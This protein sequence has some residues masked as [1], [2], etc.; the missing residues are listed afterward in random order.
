MMKALRYAFLLTVFC[1]SS[2]AADSLADAIKDGKVNGELRFWYFNQKTG[3]EKADILDL[4]V[5]LNYTTDS[6]YGFKGAFGFQSSNSPFADKDAKNMF[7]AANGLYGPGAVLSEAYI[8]YMYSK[9]ELKVGRQFINIPLVKSGMGKAVIQSFEGVTLTSGEIEGNTFYA[10]YISKFQKQTNGKGGAPNF[11]KL[12]GDYGYAIGAANNYFEKLKL[13][14]AYGGV[15]D[16]FS[17]IF[18]QADFQNSISNFNYQIAAQYSHTDYK[19]SALDD[20]NY[21]GVKFGVGFGDFNMYLAG[22]QI[23]DGNAQFGIAGGGNKCTL[24]TS[25]YEQCAE[26]EKSKQYAIDANYDFKSL[27]LLTGVR[28][29]HMDYEDTDDETDW[30]DVYIT[31]RLN[32]ISIGLAYENEN[33]KNKKD[34]NLYIARIAYKF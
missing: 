30:K 34:T 19:N 11:E 31:Y 8:S 23:R 15:K 21:Y 24:F 1:I 25:S 22:A 5:R 26:Y 13:T 16:V 10:A 32:G 29:A 9:S 4:A 12:S 27:K 28:Y 7:G 14:G 17:I 6:F 18:A 3:G 20:S 33:H 2:N